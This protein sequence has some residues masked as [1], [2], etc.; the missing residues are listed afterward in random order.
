MNENYYKYN[1]IFENQIKNNKT[2]KIDPIPTKDI[3]RFAKN[4]GIFYTSVML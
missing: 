3:T 2:V 4:I 1:K